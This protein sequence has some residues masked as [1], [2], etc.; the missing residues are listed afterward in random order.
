MTSLPLDITDLYSFDTRGISQYTP[1]TSINLAQSD[2]PN[3]G[4]MVTGPLVIRG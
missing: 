1:G 2:L 4:I 3:R